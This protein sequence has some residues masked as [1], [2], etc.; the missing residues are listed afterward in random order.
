MKL[1][2]QM[3]VA[4]GAGILFI[5]SCSKEEGLEN[6]YPTSTNSNGSL[7][8][9]FVQNAPALQSFTFNVSSGSYFIG[10][11]GTTVTV[12]PNAFV[13]QNNFPV[14]GS[15]TV[16]V[17]EV[18]NKKDMILSGGFTT[19][20][21]RPLVSGGE[22]NVTAFQGTQELKLASANSVNV[23]IPAGN[24]PPPNMYEFRASSF[25]IAN[26][27]IPVNMQAPIA[28]VS[29]SSGGYSYAFALDSLHWSNVDQFM[30][31]PGTLT[32]FSVTVPNIFNSENCMIFITVEGSQFASQIYRFDPAVRSFVSGPYYKLPE[33]LDVTFTAIAEINGQFYY[34]SNEVTI[35]ENHNTSL[36]PATTS[37]AQILQN[38]DALQ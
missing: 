15:V 23:T 29:D 28:V 14:T 9:F 12:S 2:P 10:A 27:F 37:E 7:D 8:A 1:K 34:A 18:M 31:I 33:G 24:T 32:S 16:Y 38:L 19:S 5:A 6:T 26:D 35:A 20:N 22:V 11:Q 4:I 30:N 13:Y 21:G 3:L 17:R 25:G 36:Y